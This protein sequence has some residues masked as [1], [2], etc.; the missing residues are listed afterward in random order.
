MVQK[1]HPRKTRLSPYL[2]RVY[3]HSIRDTEES[4]TESGTE[5]VQSRAF[6]R[7]HTT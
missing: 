4:D 7:V 6:G 2:L 5:S 1:I 3:A